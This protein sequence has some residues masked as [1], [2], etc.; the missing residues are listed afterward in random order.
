MIILRIESFIIAALGFIIAKGKYHMTLPQSVV[1]AIVMTI[2]LNVLFLIKYVGQIVSILL[3]IIWAYVGSYFIW[4]WFNQITWVR[5]ESFIVVFLFALA[6]H[7][8]YL[9]EYQN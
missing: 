7:F 4:N 6:P 3:S 1:I 8:T 9:E 2:I 5:I